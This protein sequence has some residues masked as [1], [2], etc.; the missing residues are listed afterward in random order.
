MEEKVTGANSSKK[1][2]ATTRFKQHM[3][4]HLNS[5]IIPY[6]EL[7]NECI[8]NGRFDKL[9]KAFEEIIIEFP[10]NI[11]ISSMVEI[12]QNDNV[13]Y[14]KRVGR[15]IFTKFVKN[16]EIKIV[17]K[18]VICMKQSS[19]NADEYFLIT[20]FPGKQTIKEP[21]DRNIKNISILEQTL[22]FWDQHAI[23]FEEGTIDSLSLTYECPYN[24]LWRNVGISRG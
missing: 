9:E 24:H 1:I 13:F 21:E 10:Y 22:L 4:V 15:D 19:S 5:F 16:R 6:E 18:C 11:G 23:V 8:Q 3:E 2:I 14:A 17:N 20:M 12:N 7:I